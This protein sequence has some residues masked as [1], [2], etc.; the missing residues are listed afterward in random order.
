MEI[1]NFSNNRNGKLNNRAFTTLRLKNDKYHIGA[2]FEIRLKGITKGTATV[3]GVNH[4]TPD[5]INGF[6]AR[7]DT[8]YPARDCRCITRK[9][10]K[11]FD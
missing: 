10:K 9:K 6:I 8:G 4:F 3:A 5:K 7:P 11:L 2:I 1:L